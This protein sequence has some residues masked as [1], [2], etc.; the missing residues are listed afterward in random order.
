MTWDNL[1]HAAVLFAASLL[2][3][4]AF[5]VVRGR[6]G[7]PGRAAL[8]GLMLAV[9]LWCLTSGLHAL[10]DS[11]STRTVISQIQYVGIAAVPPL[12]LLFASEYARLRWTVDRVLR[13]ALWVV[14]VTTMVLAAT[15]PLH[16]LIWV[17]VVPVAG[18]R[19]R[20]VHGVWFW[21][22][23]A[24]N[25]ACLAGGTFVLVRALGRSPLDSRQRV[26]LVVA[27]V[28]LPWIANLVY[29]L[30]MLPDGFDPTPIAFAVSGACI[31][32]GLYHHRLLTVVPIAR[33]LVIESMNAGVLVLDPQRVIVD[34]NPSARRL[35]GC[36][37]QDVGR[38]ID[39]TAPWW[40]DATMSAS[41]TAGT[42][43]VVD[44]GARS[45]EVQMTAVHDPRGV[46]AGWLVLIRDMAARRAA[47]AERQA[48]ERRMQEQQRVESLSVLAAGVAHDF[49]NLLTG[50]LGNAELVSMEASPGSTIRV[51]AR[52]IML[53]AQRAADL[54][55]KMLAYAGERQVAPEPVDLDALVQDMGPLLQGT[56]GR[57]CTI[58][59]E[60]AGPMPA[61]TAD[62]TQLRQVLLNLVTNSA[63]ASPDGS[64]I[65]MTTG[66]EDVTAETIAGLTFGHLSPARHAF[67]EVADSGAG[68]DEATL[69][70]VF[71]PFFSTK[72]NG[73]GLGLA[74]A[75]GIVRSHGGAL[76]I[77]SGVGRGTRVTIWLPLTPAGMTDASGPMPDPSG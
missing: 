30:R 14:P 55:D 27:G 48:L 44:V 58:T 34:L 73:R 4:W 22:V 41:A 54:V 7:A 51:N 35:A 36:G 2:A 39:L 72:A 67:L 46:L 11:I 43:V 59:Y 53:G 9:A 19:V 65:T 12:W 23:V 60:S 45:V 24:F 75:Q 63:E 32:W 61:V 50:I 26:A 62:P 16:S 28:A 33:D 49:N 17:D 56:L 70:R 1:V 29:L 15:N 31:L 38:P 66:V 40:N 6:R 71:D 13:A 77:L 5:V 3:V 57:R 42:P 21:V 10:A 18:G 76:R 37:D 64:G 25:Y 69:K 8:A 47:E 20:Y 52:A 74:T 68:I